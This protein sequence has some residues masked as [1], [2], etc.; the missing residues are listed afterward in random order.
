MYLQDIRSVRIIS[1]ITVFNYVTPTTLFAEENVSI[2]RTINI[3]KYRKTYATHFVRIKILSKLSDNF[4]HRKN[5]N[6]K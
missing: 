3:I 1:F 4:P 5:A 2:L 6:I